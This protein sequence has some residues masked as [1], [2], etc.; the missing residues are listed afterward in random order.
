[1]SKRKSRRVLPEATDSIMPAVELALET[2][3]ALP[4]GW[5]QTSCSLAE[6]INVSLADI[7]DTRAALNK[8]AL[9][10]MPASIGGP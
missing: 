9:D 5:A 10:A 3:S 7:L 6:P 8:A 4:E 1:M 2:G